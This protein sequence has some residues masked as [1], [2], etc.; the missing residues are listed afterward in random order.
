[1]KHAL[2]TTY[3][4]ATKALL[5]TFKQM[6]PSYIL[7]SVANMLHAYV[8]YRASLDLK[9]LLAYKHS[10]IRKGMPIE[11]YLHMAM[12]L[13]GLCSGKFIFINSSIL[14]QNIIKFPYMH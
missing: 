9:V 4:V 5:D 2:T 3:N 11:A 12:G 13:P 14:Q 10:H 1:M 6:F 8:W 7:T